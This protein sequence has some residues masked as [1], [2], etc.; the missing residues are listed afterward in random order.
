[1]KNIHDPMFDGLALSRAIK[2]AP[3]QQKFIDFEYYRISGEPASFFVFP[4]MKEGHNTGYVVFQ[5]ALN[6][7]SQLLTKRNKLGR[8]GETY[9]VNK[10]Q[11]LLTESRF[12]QNDILDRKIET[13][14]VRN[15]LREGDAGEKLILDYRGKWVFSSYGSFNFME[16][17]WILL[18]EIDEDEILTKLYQRHEETLYP[19]LLTQLQQIQPPGDP[20]HH[21]LTASVT[22]S[23]VRVD[24]AEMQRA[25]HGKIL[26]TVGVATCT[27]FT[28][29]MPGR[30]GYMSHLSPTDS[31][32]DLSSAANFLLGE[33]HSSFIEQTLD[34]LKWF[35]IRPFEA[36]SL[37]FGIFATQQNSLQGS[38]RQLL[39]H[40][41]DLAQIKVL[42]QPQYK[43]VNVV[44]DYSKDSIRSVWK[45]AAGQA[46]LTTSMDSV[47]NL[48]PVVRRLFRPDHA[49][50]A[51]ELAPTAENH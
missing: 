33:K 49:E 45:N 6:H 48:G 40:D 44:L 28:A 12:F 4:I 23:R 10:K 2:Q 25:D 9:L 18:A 36:A 8:S 22:T 3:Q 26:Y 50:F 51:S 5:L 32:Y 21:N 15:A 14:A 16:S 47:P 30:F 42:Y 17:T 7:I 43:M 11:L 39:N 46:A 1:M 19:R 31:A 37:Q 34:R 29:H 35:D 13:D 41:L 24:V 38:I 27:A 20:P